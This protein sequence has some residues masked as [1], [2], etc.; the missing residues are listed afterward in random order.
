MSIPTATPGAGKGQGVGLKQR[1]PGLVILPAHDPA[2]A[3]RLI[4][5]AQ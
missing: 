4:Y 2:A 3:Q 1:M 5:S